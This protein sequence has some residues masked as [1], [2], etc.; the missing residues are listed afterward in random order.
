M[1]RR[2]IVKKGLREN[3]PILEEGELAWCTDTLELFVGTK[4]GNLKIS[5][6]TPEGE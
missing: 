1:A 6:E 4:Q 3:L 2:I 5:Q